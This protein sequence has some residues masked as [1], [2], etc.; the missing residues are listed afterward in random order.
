MAQESENLSVVHLEVDAIDRLE[1]VRIDLSQV[2]DL[3]VLVLELQ[4]GHL[5]SDRLVIF[6]IKILGL[7]GV[8]FIFIVF[9]GFPAVLLRGIELFVL[10]DRGGA[11]AA[12][13]E[14]E[15]ALLAFA[16][17]ARKDLIKVET[18]Q[19]KENGGDEQHHHSRPV[20][21]ITNGLGRIAEL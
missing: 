18:E 13:G 14:A 11:L 2:L 17:G 21:I 8:D 12:H 19:S 20:R 1:A 9:Q 4:A 6:L 5:R 10:Y 3:Q 7:K 16:I 15:A